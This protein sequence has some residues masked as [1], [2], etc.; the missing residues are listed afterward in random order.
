[1]NQAIPSS[2]VRVTAAAAMP[3]PDFAP[4]V[5]LLSPFGDSGGGDVTDAGKLL[6]VVIVEIILDEAVGVVKVLSD[7]VVG[8]AA[9]FDVTVNENPL[10][11]PWWPGIDKS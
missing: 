9:A 8:V 7:H 2:S 4:V 5:R 1:M 6:L 3:M 11:P 10:T